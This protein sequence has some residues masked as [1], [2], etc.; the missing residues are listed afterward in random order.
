MKNTLSKD[1]EGFISLFDILI[2]TA[3]IILSL[4]VFTTIENIAI[5]SPIE[6]R[7]DSFNVEYI[8]ESM[9]SK[10]YINQLNILEI[11]II[12]L[13]SDNGS[14]ESIK[15]VGIIIGEY[16]NKTTNK[17]YM[18]TEINQLNSTVLAS[19]GDISESKNVSSSNRHFGDY[20]FVL[21]SW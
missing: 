19:R 8:M 2:G 13:E 12:T 18:L 15:S 5:P 4:M 1:E 6:E 7:S 10:P 17:N 9:S 14:Y 16:L 11:A 3:I 21:Y 20:N